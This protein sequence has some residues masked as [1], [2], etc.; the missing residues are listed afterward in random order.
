MDV[1]AI[2]NWSPS[3]CGACKGLYRAT[4]LSLLLNYL[5]CCAVVGITVFF[6]PDELEFTKIHAALLAILTWVVSSPFS[7]KMVEYSPRSY[8]LPKSRLL[9]Y[10]VYFGVPLLAIVSALYLAVHFNVGM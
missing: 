2:G 10:S 5:T 8:W 1:L 9:G 4:D 6:M 3:I 7:I